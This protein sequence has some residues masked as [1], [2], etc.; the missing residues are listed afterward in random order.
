MHT[1]HLA[2][3]WVY[4]NLSEQ[5]FWTAWRAAIASGTQLTVTA[6]ETGDPYYV[7]VNPYAVQRWVA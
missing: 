1:V 6:Q 7:T 5:D 4:T 3:G 2:K